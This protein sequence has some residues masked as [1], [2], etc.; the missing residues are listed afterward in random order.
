MRWRSLIMIAA[1]VIA[2]GTDV[3]ANLA[4]DDSEEVTSPQQALEEVLGE[5]AYRFC[6][7]EDYPLTIEEV[8]WCPAVGDKAPL[9]PAWPK[10]CE[11]GARWNQ[12]AGAG[13]G[14]G[15]GGRGDGRMRRR[16]R[17]NPSADRQLGAQSEPRP[18]RRRLGSLPFWIVL[19]IF[20]VIA[21]VLI[22]RSLVLGGPEDTNEPDTRPIVDHRELAEG[23]V[24]K[25]SE[26]DASRLMEMAASAARQGDHLE[27]VQLC[28]MA[29]LLRLDS[30][31]LIRLHPSRTHGDY[32]SDLRA[33]PTT[34]SSV[35]PLFRDVEPLFFGGRSATQEHYDRVS[36]R[37]MNILRQL[38]TTLCAV[39][40]L[41]IWGCGGG[42]SGATY[43]PY[44]PSGHQA[45]IEVGD[46]MHWSLSW[47]T[48]PLEG[49]EVP[50]EDKTEVYDWDNAGLGAPLVVVG[51]FRPTPDEW[52]S[53]LAWAD[54]GNTLVLA[55]GGYY[56]ESIGVSV[57][58]L[59]STKLRPV[60]LHG[61]VP[62]SLDDK[63]HVVPG[64]AYLKLT[65]KAQRVETLLSVDGKPYA[66]K[67]GGVKGREPSAGK[68]HHIYV[69]A[70]DALLTNA[71]MA[72]ADNISLT[73]HLMETFGI[74]SLSRGAELID[75]LFGAEGDTPTKKLHNIGMTPVLLQLL[76]LAIAL[77][78]WRG[79]HF[80]RPRDPVDRTRRDFGDHARALGAGY[81]RRKAADHA[82]AVYGAWLLTQLRGRA[83]GRG[84]LSE[85]AKG[86]AE[87]TSFS[88]AE[89]E[90]LLNEA[91]QKTTHDSVGGELSKLRRLAAIY[92]DL[93][94]RQ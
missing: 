49:I 30:G 75:S 8:E 48:E 17:R 84:D 4:P 29:L 76:L 41:G 20:V 50:G 14:K 72:T 19:T 31:G 25:V 51:D 2:S 11:H 68:S 9:C 26:R 24:A 38:S 60:E 42:P 83:R 55:S 63:K 82:M 74:Q 57:E 58:W 88:A 94:R 62:P 80:G 1:V 90:A 3:R 61:E 79:V 10:A 54:Q 71:G 44:G 37:A 39:I 56:L 78:L 7:Q 46:Y 40:C 89:I 67:I 6:H 93:R 32:L 15:G 64:G 70:D 91:I 22:A 12:G 5:E 45:L 87:K 28:H 59:N 16:G 18:Q 43:S 73:E 13:R 85:V 65:D 21:V 36:S 34:R 66:V 27:A 92:H 53:M 69:L 35:R 23:K 77:L 81:A 52:T 33:H 47:R 86:A